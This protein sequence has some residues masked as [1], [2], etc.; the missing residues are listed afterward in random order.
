MSA[1]SVPKTAA[2]FQTT[3]W[4]LIASARDK[5]A[6]FERLLT[7]YWNPI[8]GYIRRRGYSQSDADDLT[9]QFIMSKVIQRE[10]IGKADATLG[11]FRT[12]V[13]TCL[14]RFLV[15]EMRR[16]QPTMSMS[17]EELEAQ[18]AGREGGDPDDAFHL[19]WATNVLSIVMERLEAECQRDGMM[20]QWRVFEARSLRPAVH[21]C[22]R[23]T[24]ESLM[25]ELNVSE[26]Q[27]IY[28]MHQTIQNKAERIIEEIVAATVD[29]P[30]D[31]SSEVASLRRLLAMRR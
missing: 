17:D 21:N 15:D 12:F 16:P 31:V 2:G 20:K 19:E 25:I 30:D 26:R 6:D 29:A 18:G 4:T 9:Q 14:K 8:Y 22:E 10:L 3:S 27:V 5:P 11:K 1:A 24:I 13:L 28:S 7:L 23:A